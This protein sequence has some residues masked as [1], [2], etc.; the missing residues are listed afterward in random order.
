VG[1][2]VV[3]I[4]QAVRADGRHRHRPQRFPGPVQLASVHESFP[5]NLWSVEIP[6]EEEVCLLRDYK[7]G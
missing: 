2:I 4:D 1:Q 3:Q 7:G 6:H 5:V